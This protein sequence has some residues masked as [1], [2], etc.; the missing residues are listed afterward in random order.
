MLRSWQ[1]HPRHWPASAGGSRLST[2]ASAAAGA[3]ARACVCVRVWQCVC[4]RASVCA[5]VC[6]C[7]CSSVGRAHASCGSSG[8]CLDGRTSPKSLIR[9]GPIC[10]AELTID[11]HV[12]RHTPTGSQPTEYSQVLCSAQAGAGGQQRKRM[13][14]GHCAALCER[15]RR[16]NKLGYVATGCG[17]AGR[18]GTATAA[19]KLRPCENAP[20]TRLQR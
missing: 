11:Q 12:R 13:W 5:T 19:R 16:C 18:S 7:S 15:C 10:N 1:P 9:S 8:G 17:R 14:S 3:C 6:V 2:Q 4:V 20:Q